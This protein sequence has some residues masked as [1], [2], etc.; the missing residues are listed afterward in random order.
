MQ[1]FASSFIFAFGILY[2]GLF[3]FFVLIYYIFLVV[4]LFFI[5]KKKQTKQGENKYMGYL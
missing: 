1:R 5:L 2:V 4:L 3:L